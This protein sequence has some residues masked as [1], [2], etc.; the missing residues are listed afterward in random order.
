MK[1]VEST[2]AI[3]VYVHDSSNTFAIMYE[4]GL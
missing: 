1:E 4:M 3:F 2:S